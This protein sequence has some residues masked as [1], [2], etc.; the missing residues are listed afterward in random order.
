MTAA[1][2]GA[3]LGP[4]Y[5]AD[6]TG[7]ASGAILTSLVLLPRFGLAGVILTVLVLKAVSLSLQAVR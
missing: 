4:L 2:A 6:L 1:G 3:I 5:L 7:A